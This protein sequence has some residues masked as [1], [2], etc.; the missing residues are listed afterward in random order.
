MCGQYS[1][2]VEVTA[3]GQDPDFFLTWHGRCLY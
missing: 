3:M 1:V 2:H